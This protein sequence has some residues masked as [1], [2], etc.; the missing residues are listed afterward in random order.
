[1]KNH[2]MLLFFTEARLGQT[3]NRKFYSADQSFS[4]QMFER[5][6]TVFSY[7]SVVA[8][9]QAIRDK[10]F[11]KRAR[12]DG[13]KVKVLPLPY[14]IGPFQYLIKRNKFTKKLRKYID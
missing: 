5:Y 14:Y 4:Y 6:L 2:M 3:A 11:D 12:V 13:D 9:C 7:V 10:S 8:R 1:M